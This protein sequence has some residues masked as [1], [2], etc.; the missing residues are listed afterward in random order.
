MESKIFPE[1]FLL[2]QI[3]DGKGRASHI[4]QYLPKRRGHIRRQKY[5]S[6][7]EYKPNIYINVFKI[8]LL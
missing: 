7:V 1:M 3:E 6:E 4:L 8:F 5:G 2:I